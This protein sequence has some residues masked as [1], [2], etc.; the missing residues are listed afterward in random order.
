MIRPRVLHPA[1]YRRVP[2]KN[3]LGTTL[4]LATD[5]P[6]PGGPWTW[7]MSIADVPA[8]SAFSRFEGVDRQIAVLEGGGMRLWPARDEPCAV[9]RVGGAL[10]FR[11]EDALEGE[12]VGAG[13]RD[14]NLMVARK[15]WRAMLRVVRGEAPALSLRADVSIAYLHAASRAVELEADGER[16][17]ISPGSLVAASWISLGATSADAVLVVAR[18]E[19][20]QHAL[21]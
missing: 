8:R 21:V 20:A 15:A 16:M 19:R 18:L 17:S 13:V 3:G 6:E 12:P 9:P 1:D 11:G 14:V 5:A 7:R 2:W 4:E 10:R